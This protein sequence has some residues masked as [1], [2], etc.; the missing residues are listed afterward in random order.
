[1]SPLRRA[2]STHFILNLYTRRNVYPV[3]LALIIKLIITFPVINVLVSRNHFSD[4]RTNSGSNSKE[5]ACEACS[6]KF[7]LFKRKVS[8]PFGK[9]RAPL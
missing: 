7:N 3:R 6:T 1:M 9:I 5:M 4:R 8:K 2:C